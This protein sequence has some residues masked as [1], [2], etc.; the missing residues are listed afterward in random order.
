MMSFGS[1]PGIPR[2]IAGFA[3]KWQLSITSVCRARQATW[4]A[5]LP[6]NYESAPGQFVSI[7]VCADGRGA[8]R[9]AQR[10]LGSIDLA[11]PAPGRLARPATG[12]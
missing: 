9:E 10:I 6:I 12:G 11:R 1:L 7:E 8:A 5:V 3:A 2:T 4:G